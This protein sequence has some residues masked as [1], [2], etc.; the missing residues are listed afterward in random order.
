[1]QFHYIFPRSLLRWQ[2]SNLEINDIANLAFIAGRTNRKLSNQSPSVYSTDVMAKTGVG[3]FE[4]QAIPTQP[5]LVEVEA[6]PRFFEERRRQ[7]A[8]RPNAFLRLD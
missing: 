8:E 7:V 3:P 5:D 4:A 6:G 2:Y 1:M